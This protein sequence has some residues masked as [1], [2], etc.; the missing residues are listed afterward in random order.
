MIVK[1]VEQHESLPVYE[2]VGGWH[3][4][5]CRLGKC[6]GDWRESGHQK[7]SERYSIII[8]NFLFESFCDTCFDMGIK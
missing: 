3:L 7:V 1:T 4:R 2:T 6:A 8:I 5:E